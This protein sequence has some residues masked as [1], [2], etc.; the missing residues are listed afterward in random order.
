[1]SCLSLGSLLITCPFPLD[2][3]ASNIMLTIADEDV[4]VDFETAERDH[5]SPRKVIDDKR[6]IYVSGDIRRPRNHAWGY[7]VLCDFG[8]ARIGGSYKHEWIQ[9]ELYRAPEIIMETGWS[10]SVDIWNTAC[11]V[12]VS[13]FTVPRKRKDIV[14]IIWP[15]LGSTGESS[16]F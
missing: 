12:R 15:D 10:H 9:P 2:I 5:P 4:L 7:P 14:L 13:R 6:S 11:V 8:E 1:M 3:K 16:S